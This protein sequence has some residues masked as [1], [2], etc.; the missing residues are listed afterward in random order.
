MA[1]V[2]RPIGWETRNGKE[3]TMAEDRLTLADVLGKEEAARRPE[4]CCERRSVG[5]CSS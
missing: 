5:W 2:Y 1:T 3:Y 4:T